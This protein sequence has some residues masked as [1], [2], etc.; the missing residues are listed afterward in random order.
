MFIYIC[1][2]NATAN[3]KADGTSAL[4]TDADGIP[5]TEWDSPLWLPRPSPVQRL[6]HH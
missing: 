4:K 6:S 2:Q 3:S 1:P 5:W